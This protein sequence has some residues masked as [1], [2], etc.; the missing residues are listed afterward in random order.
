MNLG[1]RS[2]FDHPSWRTAVGTA[3]SY[4]V[5]LLAMFFFLFVVPFAVFVLF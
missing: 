1:L 5:I 4:A 2:A 3:V